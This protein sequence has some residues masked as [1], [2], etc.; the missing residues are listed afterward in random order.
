MSSP[1]LAVIHEHPSWQEPLFEV[2]D[3]RGVDYVA[4]D[5]KSAAFD[6]DRAIQPSVI[7]NQASPSAY[8]RGNGHTVSFALALLEDLESSGLK[9]LNGSAAFRLELSKIAQVRLMR[10]LGMDY[11]RTVAFNRVEAL[12][13][14]GKAIRFPAILKPNQGGSGARMVEV[15]SL[16]ELTDV[17][18]SDPSLWNPD[19]VLLLQEKLEHD[20]VQEGIVR[21]EFLDG[22]LLYAMRVVGGSGFNLCPSVDCNPEGDEDGTCAIPHTESGGNPSFL[23]YPDI[24]AEIVEEGRRLFSATGFDVG[25]LEYLVTSDG[26]RVFYDIN[27]NSNLRRSV[28]MAMGFDPFDRVAEYLERKIAAENGVA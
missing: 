8:V 27:A 5:L 9:V 15:G 3:R 17:L 28:G 7:F 12:E 22:E 4:Y 24:P 1:A 16:G 21:M 19:P 6:P 13:E 23:P 25:A 10:Q 11:P 20:P 26:R 2:L 18:H 14:L